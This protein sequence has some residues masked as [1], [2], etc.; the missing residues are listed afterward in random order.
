MAY[1]PAHRWRVLT[2]ATWR[3]RQGLARNEPP[4][5]RPSTAND[6]LVMGPGRPLPPP[7]LGHWGQEMSLPYA[8]APGAS[9]RDAL[10]GG[11]KE[12]DEAEDAEAERIKARLAAMVVSRP[13]RMVG[14][15]STTGT[16]PVCFMAVTT[17]KDLHARVPVGVGPR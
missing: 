5:V 12:F 11:A 9:A 10:T 2:D 14:A 17:P 8:V 3:A 16:G 1:A 6:A 13:S 4:S 7:S 15:R